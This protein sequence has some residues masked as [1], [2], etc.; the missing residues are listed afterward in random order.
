MKIFHVTGSFPYSQ[1]GGLKSPVV[2]MVRT[3]K[4][5]GHEVTVIMPH[6]NYLPEVPRTVGLFGYSEGIL[7]GIRVIGLG[8]TVSKLPVNRHSLVAFLENKNYYLDLAKYFVDPSAELLHPNETWQQTLKQEL[9]HNPELFRS[10]RSR[11]KGNSLSYINPQKNHFSSEE[12]GLFTQIV[13]DA[14]MQY[15]YSNRSLFTGPR[16]NNSPLVRFWGKLM[17]PVYQRFVDM[18]ERTDTPARVVAVY[19]SL[20]QQIEI[21]ENIFAKKAETRTPEITTRLTISAS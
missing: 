17:E 14:F 1:N 15:Y 19:N 5:A 3:Q 2:E 10:L 12:Y 6:S 8:Q 4:R 11:I 7:D 21:T 18:I 13:R 20:G 9:D 16:K